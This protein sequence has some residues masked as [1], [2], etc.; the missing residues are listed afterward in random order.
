M[1]SS[2]K[3][4]IHNHI[5][6]YLTILAVVLV[7]I[8]AGAFTINGL[9]SQQ[10]KELGD[11]VGGYLRILKNQNV[12]TT[13]L[14]FISL[15]NNFVLFLLVFLSGMTIIGIPFAYFF[16]AFNAFL[17]GFSIGLIVKILGYKGILYAFVSVFPSEIF[18][19]PAMI[20]MA[21]NAVI[22]SRNTIKQLSGKS[23]NR[24][25]FKENLFSYLMLTGFCMLVLFL[26]II[27][28]GYISPL[29]TKLIVP[30][31]I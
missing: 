22:F 30:L 19:I 13:S 27:Y 16:V 28:E 12:D 18:I 2:L 29:I 10:Q 25:S 20:L 9:S 24:S 31:L 26:G 4:H 8:C 21:A 6:L 5:G 15:K 3:E 1:Y 7:G 17:T 14:F 23:L 11:Y